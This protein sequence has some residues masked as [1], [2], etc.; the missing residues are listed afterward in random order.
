MADQHWQLEGTLAQ[1]IYSPRGAIEGLLLD[2]DGAVAQFVVDKHEPQLPPN[3]KTGQKLNL[4][5]ALRKPSPKGEAEH[6]V[7][8]LVEIVGNSHNAEKELSGK[9]VRLNFAKHGEANG[10]ILESGDFIHTKP[11]GLRELGWKVGDKVKAKG[12]THPL[13]TGSGVVLE[14]QPA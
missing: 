5:G 1:L 6:E 11:D 9:I 10:V 12:R 2:V 4:I 8:D 14:W 3:L 13:A 7:Y